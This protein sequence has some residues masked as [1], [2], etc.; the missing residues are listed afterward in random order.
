M[1]IIGHSRSS[2]CAATR[3]STD[4]ARFFSDTLAS[5]TRTKGGF[6]PFAELHLSFSTGARVCGAAPP[7][8]CMRGSFQG[9]AFNLNM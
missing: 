2:A 7:A 5:T 9:S 8:A 6:I 1:I 3:V 4:H